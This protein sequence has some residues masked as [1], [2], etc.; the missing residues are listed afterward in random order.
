MSRLEW[1]KKE[2]ER[3]TRFAWKNIVP[4]KKWSSKY[5]IKAWQIVLLWMLAHLI[6]ISHILSPKALIKDQWTGMCE[7][8]LTNQR[9]L[10]LNLLFKIDFVVYGVWWKI[11]YNVLSV[12]P[13]KS[14]Q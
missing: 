5:P 3:K 4:W 12:N 6:L 8:Q 11:Q 13:N 9:P 2:N 10:V 14:T 7:R 1:R